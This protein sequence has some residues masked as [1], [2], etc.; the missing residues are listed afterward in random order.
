MRLLTLVLFGIADDGVEAFDHDF[1]QALVDQLLVPE[2]A[3]AVLHPLEV[4]DGDAAGVGQDIGD[5]ED[6]LLGENLVGERRGGTVG[7]F[8]EDLAAH[9]VRRSAR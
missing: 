3:L 7:A 5:H 8:A 6:F 2:E 1:L 4:G 9:A